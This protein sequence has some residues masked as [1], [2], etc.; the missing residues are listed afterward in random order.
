[1]LKKIKTW[2]AAIALALVCFASFGLMLWAANT[3]SAIMDE[4]AHIPAGYGYV[5]QLDYRLNPEHPPLIKALA[6]LP[7]YLFE[8]P[9]YPTNISAWTHAVNGEWDMGVAFLYQSGNDANTIIRTAR[10]MPILI[11]ILTIILVW[12]LARRLVGDLWALLPAFMFAFDPAVLANGHYVTTDVGAAFGTLLSLLFFLGY[13]ES[14]ST[15]RLWYAGIAFG[16]AQLTKFS[17]P[18]LIP[19][20]LFLMIIL[21]VRDCAP[22]WRTTVR[23]WRTFFETLV[24]YLWKIVIIFAIGYV[25]IVYPVYFLFTAHEPIARQASDT[26]AILASFSGGPTPAG[27]LCHGLRCFADADIWMSQHYATRPIAQYL[28]GILMVLQRA[29]GGNTIYFLGHVAQD[30]GWIYFPVLFL[31]KEPIPTLVIVFLA[32]AL[33]A[34]W[35]IKRTADRWRTGAGQTIGQRALA[36][37]HLNFAEFSMASFVALYWGIS[38]KSPLNIGIRHLMPTI[39]LIFI[40]ATVVWKKWVMRLNFGSFDMALMDSARAMARSVAVAGVKYLFLIL[41]L[42]WLLLETLFAAPYF[43]SYFNEFGGGVWGG[44][45]FVTDSN[46]DWGQDLLRLQS[47]VNAHPGIDK[48]AVDYF[49]GGDPHYYLGSKEVNWSPSMGNP[50]DHGIHWLAISVN[51]LELATQPLLPGEIRNASDTYAWLTA[52]RPPADAAGTWLGGTMGNV[53]TP[54]YRAGTSIFIY[55]L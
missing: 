45:H 9:T 25:V 12:F 52:L 35:T 26:V 13:F 6:A 46:Y 34:W 47:F 40:L 22:Q 8:H 1:M 28:L 32:L 20:Y 30:G 49:G 18:L 53:P 24:R 4:L 7:V 16:I 43:L 10:I 36:Y 19:L 39:P 29:D 11:T 17:T 33:A 37:L 23:R 27:H 55:H 21:A 48:I 15:K 44:Y 31:L 54:D 51:Q 50:A 5:S 38:M 2:S 41:L 3:D 42:S 14:P